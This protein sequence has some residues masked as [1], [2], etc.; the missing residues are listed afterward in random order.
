VVTQNARKIEPDFGWQPRF[1]DRIVRDDRSLKRIRYYI[2][3]N[4]KNWRKDRFRQT[5]EMETARGN[6]VNS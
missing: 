6:H 2:I 5:Q 3:N 1:Y 4:P